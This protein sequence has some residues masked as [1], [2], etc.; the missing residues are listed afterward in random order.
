MVREE[1]VT[2]SSVDVARAAVAA[3]ALMQGESPLATRSNKG[4][5]SHFSGEAICFLQIQVSQQSRSPKELYRAS[6]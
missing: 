2:I 1:P 4:C 5:N 6:I 3:M